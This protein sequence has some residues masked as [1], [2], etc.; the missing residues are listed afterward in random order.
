MWCVFCYVSEGEYQCESD[1]YQWGIDF[2]V[3]FKTTVGWGVG[4]WEGGRGL[5]IMDIRRSS[6]SL[7]Y[8]GGKNELKSDRGLY[9][10]IMKGMKIIK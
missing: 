9:D 8:Y 4:G 3:L 7:H 6:T 1:S 10:E 5:Y 2:I